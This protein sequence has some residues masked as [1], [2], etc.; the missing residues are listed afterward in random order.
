MSKI[1]PYTIDMS[2]VHG[3]LTGQLLANVG[4]S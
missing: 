1:T 2:F 4:H 3:E